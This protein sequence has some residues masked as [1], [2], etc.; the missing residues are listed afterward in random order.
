MK[1]WLVI[2]LVVL[3][4]LVLVSPGLIGELAQKNVEK[5]IS[6]AAN[7]S[8]RATVTT[9]SFDK[10]WFTS[11]GHYRVVFEEGGLREALDAAHSGLP[12][13]LIKTNIEHGLLP[14][15][16]MIPGIAS[17]TSTAQVDD[18]RGNISDLPGTLY[19]RIGLTGDS[20]FNYVAKPGSFNFESGDSLDWEGADIS[21]KS[22]ANMTSFSVDGR[23]NPLQLKGSQGNMN[24]GAI[25]VKGEQTKT[26]VGIDVGHGSFDL[27][28][29]WARDGGGTT[30]LK[31]L[32]FDSVSALN[33]D[34]ASFVF[35]S[36]VDEL[37]LPGFEDVAYDLEIE[38]GKLD[39]EKLTTI[40]DSLRA[41]QGAAPNQ[42]PA[43]L[44]PG[45]EADVLQL[46]SSGAHIGIN[47]FNLT[48]PQGDVAMALNLDIEKAAA[49]ASANWLSLLMA[50]DATATVS[51]PVE[52]VNFFQS[53]NPEIGGMIAMGL[54]QQDGDVYRM[55]AR[56]N[57]ALLTVNGAPLP[58]PMPG[59]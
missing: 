46:L 49:G 55:E 40:I 7:E 2:L 3:A 36:R 44:Y 10:G 56:F 21:V 30:A 54:L 41:L 14:L 5:G 20:V 4:V 22:N 8:G 18:G 19:T 53:V 1:R 58:L 50:L 12:S 52:L 34:G 15:S 39:P 38:L 43:D 13:L 37:D 51:A 33:N 11:E 47:R 16:E 32:H 35:H 31:G 45:A 24:V 25:T 26:D 59:R 29:L 28:T 48:L 9:E 27:E 42:A 17:A 57:K 23:I 6:Q